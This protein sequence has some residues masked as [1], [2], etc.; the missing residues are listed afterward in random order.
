[1]ELQNNNFES[2]SDNLSST[3]EKLK[4]IINSPEDLEI[5]NKVV[6]TP[7]ELALYA[8][9]VSDPDQLALMNKIVQDPEE[10]AAF[11]WIVTDKKMSRE[12]KIIISQNMRKN[13]LEESK[14]VD[15]DST[16]AEKDLD[17]FFSNWNRSTD[18]RY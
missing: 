6:K 4:T 17:D 1:M 16:D 14:E 2:S 15:K 12:E 11:E 5:I 13:L 8:W 18:Y 10:L 9:V 3:Q 7:E